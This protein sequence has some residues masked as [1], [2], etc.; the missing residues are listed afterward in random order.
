MI[1]NEIVLKIELPYDL[2]VPLLSIY[3]YNTLFRKD[4][5]GPVFTAEQSR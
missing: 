3:P 2:V 1:K 4:I 5:L